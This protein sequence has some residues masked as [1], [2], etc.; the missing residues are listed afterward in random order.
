MIVRGADLKIAPIVA[1]APIDVV[2]M[3][4]PLRVGPGNSIEQM[5]VRNFTPVHV[6][7]VPEGNAIVGVGGP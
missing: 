1:S 6:R 2:E 3:A 4:L 7:R 5:A